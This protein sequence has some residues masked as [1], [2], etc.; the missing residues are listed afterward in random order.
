M[1]YDLYRVG[2]RPEQ[3]NDSTKS[4]FGAGQDFCARGCKH[5]CTF[6][7]HNFEGNTLGVHSDLNVPQE[8]LQLRIF[9]DLFFDVFKYAFSLR[10][11]VFLVK[12]CRVR[13]FAGIGQCTVMVIVPN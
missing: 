9:G 10:S 12:P 5:G 13:R 2:E 7:I 4:A 6:C 8:I 1:S 11:I 3:I